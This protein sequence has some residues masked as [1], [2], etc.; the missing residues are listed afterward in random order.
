MNSIA[1]AAEAEAV[2]ISMLKS[3]FQLSPADVVPRPFPH[4][5][6]QDILEPDFYRQ[7]KAEFPVDSLFDKRGKRMG[8]RTGRDLY[9]GDSGFDEFIEQSSAWRRLYSCM[10]SPEFL[11]FTLEMIGPYFDEFRC[12]VSADKAQLVSHT[13]NRFSVWWRARKARWF[14][15]GATQDPDKV[16]VRFDI[17]QSDTGYAKPVHC[18]NQSRLVSFLVYFCDADEIGLEGGDLRIH[19]HVED[20]LYSDSERFPKESDTKVIR[21]LRPRDNLG[22]FFLCSNNSYHSVTPVTRSRDYRRFIYTNL[23][24]TA[25]NIW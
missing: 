25:E 19:A 18:D 9:R 23:S 10:N 2:D 14:G 21:T 8:A 12:R 13:E 22:L 1:N 5:I 4:V 3:I 17:E 7:L 24:S 20:K 16:F 11:K 6:K 15:A